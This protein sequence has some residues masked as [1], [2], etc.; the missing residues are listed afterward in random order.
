VHADSLRV[1]LLVSLWLASAV[2]R[3]VLR[4]L[5]RHN[6]G[7]LLV[8]S[9]KVNMF[10]FSILEHAGL[11]HEGHSVRRQRETATTADRLWASV[12]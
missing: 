10:A 6:G 12:G 2:Q 4:I 7:Q 1:E 11:E 3:H 5:A 8:N 9:E